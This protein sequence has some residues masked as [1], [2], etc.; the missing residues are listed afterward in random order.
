MMTPLEL[1][2]IHAEAFDTP[3]DEASF[4]ELLR[5]PEVHLSGDDRGFILIRTVADEAEIL[6]VA[7]R[8]SARRQGLGRALV[9]AAIVA[10]AAFG[11]KKMFLEVAESNV[12]AIALYQSS[13]FETVG[14]RK[15]Y[16]KRADGKSE[17]AKVMV[18]NISL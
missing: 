18:L 5:S 12:A 3:W 17:H 6:T 10:S 8:P 13:G 14:L 16:Y 4:S 11:A 1:A 15:N 9:E 2:S 7:V